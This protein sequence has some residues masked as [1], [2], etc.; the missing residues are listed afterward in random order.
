MTTNLV[1]PV[2]TI[3]LSRF[4]EAAYPEE[5]TGWGID[6]SIDGLIIS[7][8][9][10]TF[11]PDEKASG[12]LENGNFLLVGILTLQITEGSLHDMPFEGKIK[13]PF[14]AELERELYPAA[15]RDVGAA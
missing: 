12:W 11:A 10:T 7:L 5:L 14:S 15:F 8:C 4:W 2:D 1:T 9:E 6:E 3:T 13:Y